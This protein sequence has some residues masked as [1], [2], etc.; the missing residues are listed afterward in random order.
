MVGRRLRRKRPSRYT[1]M[2]TFQVIL[3]SVP[4]G[5]SLLRALTI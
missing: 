2:V 1:H 5:N 3:G 4:T